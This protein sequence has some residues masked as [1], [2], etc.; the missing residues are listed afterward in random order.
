MLQ[1]DQEADLLA[2]FEV[3]DMVKVLFLVDRV[4][5][6]YGKRQ[7]HLSVLIGKAIPPGTTSWRSSRQRIH[8]EVAQ[9]S[10]GM[11]GWVMCDVAPPLCVF[12]H[13]GIERKYCQDQT[14]LSSLTTARRE[15]VILQGA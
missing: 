3:E 4:A 8:D 6:G 13:L 15:G 11:K 10:R 1:M 14:R 7:L 12:P 9:Q 5:N 2:W